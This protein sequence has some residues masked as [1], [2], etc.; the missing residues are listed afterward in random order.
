MSHKQ[1]T[2]PK[3]L[4]LRDRVTLAALMLL[5]SPL[6]LADWATTLKEQTKNVQIGLYAIAAILALGTL[7]WVGIKWMISR[8][9]G[10]ME[11]TLMDY[12]KQI[13]VVAV[14]GGVIALGTAAWQLFGG[15]GL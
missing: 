4:T 1:C 3:K 5:A 11:T 9:N 6:A 14:V 12:F 13:G 7:T 2:L 15:T 8:A 10:D